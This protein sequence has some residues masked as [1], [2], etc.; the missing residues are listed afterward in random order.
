MWGRIQPPTPAQNGN[1]QAKAAAPLAAMSAGL[2]PYWKPRLPYGRGSDQSRER[3]RA[4]AH[5]TPNHPVTALTAVVVAILLA[6]ASCAPARHAA[7]SLA[8]YIPPGT[9][10]IAY[11]DLDRL[12]GTAIYTKLPV[13]EQ[14]RDASAVLVI[15]QGRDWAI[16]ARGHFPQ[17]PAGATLVGPDIAAAGAPELL[18][19]MQ[20]KPVGGADLLA[21][22]PADAPVWLVARG[23]ATLPITGNLANFNRLLHQA[24]YTAIGLRVTNRVEIDATAQCATEAQARHLEENVRALASLARL[25]AFTVSSDGAVV[26]VG[27][28]LAL[29]S[30]PA[31]R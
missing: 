19:A 2:I 27:A 11:A 31:L 6:S 23:R 21:R 12:R 20:S 17:P 22:A 5:K 10:A 15:L 16:A 24:E 29:N 25:E 13:P 9:D 14:L 18:R 8:A 1:G 30:L 4:V 28:A 26:H 7:S 3:E